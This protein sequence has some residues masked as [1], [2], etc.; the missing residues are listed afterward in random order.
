MLQQDL[1]KRGFVLYLIVFSFICSGVY[2]VIFS[3]KKKKKTQA[4]R[5]KQSHLCFPLCRIAINVVG[6]V[7]IYERLCSLFSLDIFY[8]TTQKDSR[9]LKSFL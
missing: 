4:K 2:C 7:K 9:K 1:K 3:K 6:P 5:R 8:S